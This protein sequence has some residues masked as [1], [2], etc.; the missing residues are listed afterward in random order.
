MNI[1]FDLI[2]L[3]NL[4]MNYIILFATGIVLKIKMKNFKLIISSLMGSFYAIII[5]LKLVQLTENIIMKIILSFCM[6]WVAFESKTLKQFLKHLIMF[7]G[8]SFIFGGCAFALIYFI[9][10]Q[11]VKIR[12]GVLVGLY[13]IKI[14]IIAGAVA[15]IVIQIIFRINRNKLTT[16]DIIC[17]LEIKIDNKLI[18]TK[19]LIDSGNMLKDPISHYPVI[20]INKEVIKDDNELLNSLNNIKGGEINSKYENKI[21]LIPFT[22]L[23]N[24]NGMLIGIKADGVKIFYEDQNRIR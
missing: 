18:K 3:E 16:K 17:R 4:L 15:F 21:R 13:P 24:K 8:I 20:I 7:Y 12:N 1:Y 9:S 14:T 23:G 11:N 10:P 22:S 2:L 19:A 6:V 5:Y